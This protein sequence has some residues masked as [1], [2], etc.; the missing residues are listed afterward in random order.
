MFM[1]WACNCASSPVFV[2]YLLGLGRPT[3][4]FLVNSGI[5]TT[6]DW[7]TTPMKGYCR[8]HCGVDVGGKGLFF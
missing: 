3:I 1:I 7:V 8:L 4:D 2:R 5:Y 6:I